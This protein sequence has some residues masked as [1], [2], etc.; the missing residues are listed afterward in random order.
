MVVL[1]GVGYDWG[2]NGVSQ[3]RGGDAKQLGMGSIERHFDDEI[4]VS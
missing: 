3:G 2:G 1:G 4:C